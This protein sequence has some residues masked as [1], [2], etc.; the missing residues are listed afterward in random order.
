MVAEEVGE[1]PNSGGDEC[2]CADAFK[3]KSNQID[4]LTVPVSLFYSR[5]CYTRKML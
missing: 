3:F 1:R 4:L 5:Q 2:L